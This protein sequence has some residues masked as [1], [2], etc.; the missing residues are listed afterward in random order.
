MDIRL[1]ITW[2][3]TKNR[4][5]NKN[6]IKDEENHLTRAFTEQKRESFKVCDEAQSGF[7]FNFK[8]R[9][10]SK[11]FKSETQDAEIKH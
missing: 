2:E 5:I 3:H 4:F 8:G 7:N 6:I 9:K 10:A 11:T 1:K